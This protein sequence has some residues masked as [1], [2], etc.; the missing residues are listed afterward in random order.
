MCIRDRVSMSVAATL[1]VAFL[2]GV[3]LQG[4][5]NGVWPLAASVYPAAFRATGIGWAIG[6]GRSGA[7]IGP[8][9]GGYLMAAKVALPILFAS[10]CV[11]LLLC[12]A[13]VVA[14]R[15]ISEN[16]VSE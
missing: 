8:M 14:V 1:A 11:P 12:A 5:Y 7:I 10:Y 3:L 4:G 16:R 6:I 15:R 13:C 9:L 2:I